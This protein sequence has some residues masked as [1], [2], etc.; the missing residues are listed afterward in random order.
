[1][2]A[3]QD[4]P[5][6]VRLGEVIP[7]EDPE[8]W[9]RPLTWVVALGML[10]GPA[11][12]AAWFMLGGPASADGALPGTYLV[13]AALAGGAAVTGATQRGMARAGTATLGAG[14]FAALLVIVLGAVAAG[15]RQAGASSPA[16]AHAFAAAIGGVGGALAASVVAALV[17]RAA[18]PLVRFG[19]AV[20]AGAFVAAAGVAALLP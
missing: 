13:A 7:P 17:A 15:E 10:A 18:P 2:S 20:P 14:L 11:A 8:D 6:S 9:T 4:A 16:M 19:S 5:I 1:M 3:P 12:A